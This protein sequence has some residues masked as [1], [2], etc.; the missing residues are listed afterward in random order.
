MILGSAR[1]PIRKRNNFILGKNKCVCARVCLC[2][3]YN[4]HRSRLA[5]VKV[6]RRV[7]KHFDST[8]SVVS[9]NSTPGLNDF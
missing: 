7:K 3:K 6:S 2:V 4:E 8:T 1:S 5:N 9:F